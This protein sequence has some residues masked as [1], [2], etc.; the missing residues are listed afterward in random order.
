MNRRQFVA[1]AIAAPLAAPLAGVVPARA[2]EPIYIAD[3]HFHL[4]F[5]GR[6]PASVQPLAP[7]MAAGQVTL[8][9]W[10]LVG[11]VPWLRPVKG[12]F[13]PFGAPKP[14]EA[15][16]WFE[17][18][19][20]R[21]EAHLAEQKLKV[22]RTVGDLERARNGEP[23]VLLSVEGATFA[24]DGI[25][26]IRAAHARGIRHIQL[27]HFIRNTIGD[28]QTEPPEH[29]GLTAYGRQVIEECNR[30]GI[31]IDLAHCTAATVRQALA[32]S[33]APMIWSHSSVAFAGKPGGPP[34]A[35]HARQLAVAEAKAI[36]AKGGVVGLWALG[37]DV[38]RGPEAYA[39]RIAD[40]IDGLGEDH[41]GFGTDMNALAAP[42]IT[43]FADLRRVVAILEHRKLPEAR[44]RKLAMDNYVRVLRLAFQ[45]KAA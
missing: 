37:A 23:H 24:D 4:F 21:V 31:L 43:N 45:A 7:N 28:M 38:G 12:G 19:L 34:L 30:L 18:E 40:L 11:D 25:A 9:S 26:Q 6:R 27:V 1:A 14:G 5:M 2:R 35:W 16:T 44:I 41:V 42:A 10:S 36:A 33:K 3:M 8:A 29:G 20:G 32:V 22:A 13:K 15:T 39:Q 17:A